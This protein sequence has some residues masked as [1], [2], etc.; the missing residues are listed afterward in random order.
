MILI[1]MTA[2]MRNT[3][4]QPSGSNEYRLSNPHIVQKA[5]I[6]VQRPRPT[7]SIELRPYATERAL[8]HLFRPQA[9]GQ[10]IKEKRTVVCGAL[11]TF[12]TGL[13]AHER[14]RDR[15]NSKQRHFV[16]RESDG[17]SRRSL[18]A[19]AAPVWHLMSATVTSLVVCHR[20]MGSH[21]NWPHEL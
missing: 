1:R 9:H 21:R 7:K 3:V 17:M 18:T 6:Q 13:F 11:R 14:S 20:K 16:G 2:S 10:T 19:N 12:P 4:K 5:N 15:Q 8:W